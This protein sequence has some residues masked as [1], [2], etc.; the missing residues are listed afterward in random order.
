MAELFD[1]ALH[2]FDR[3]ARERFGHV[4]DSATDQA[5]ARFGV[6]FAKFAYPSCYFGKKIAGLKLEI[7][8][9][10]ISHVFGSGRRG[11]L[12]LASR[13]NGLNL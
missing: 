9:V 10:Q 12:V 7:I 1:S 4:A 2:R 3:R 5:L 6:R 8:F 13:Q 11:D